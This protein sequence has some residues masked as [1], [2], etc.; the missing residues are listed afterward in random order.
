MPPS[1]RSRVWSR[2]LNVPTPPTPLA[3]AYYR[4]LIRRVQQWDFAVDDMYRR[5]IAESVADDE[6]Y[7]IFADMVEELLM[8]F[9]RDPW[10]HA[11]ASLVP[12]RDTIAA[13]FHISLPNVASAASPSPSPSPSAA[14]ASGQKI[15]HSWRSGPRFAPE[16][17]LT[18]SAFV[19][20]R[21]SGV[22]SSSVSPT[23][24][25]SPPSSAAATAT[26]AV[27]RLRSAGPSLTQIDTPS[28]LPPCGVMPFHGIA[29]FA[30]PLTYVFDTADKG[31][32][33][34]RTL[35]TVRELRCL[36]AYLNHSRALV[37]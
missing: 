12:A 17:P 32:F 37:C 18:V 26:A 16:S 1:L 13:A 33:L 30:A 10:V 6:Q 36:S 34:F 20:R 2:L 25:L 3:N 14:A 35:Y 7:F 22:A 29:L 21:P 19:E 31:Y 24:P 15:S 27:L 28:M 23:S 8:C 9:S 11:N 4:T 5:D